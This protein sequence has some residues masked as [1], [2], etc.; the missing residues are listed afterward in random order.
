M[1]ARVE[2]GSASFSTRRRPRLPCLHAVSDP[3]GAGYAGTS[4]RTRCA[5]SSPRLPGP[6]CRSRVPA[7][8]RPARR[9]RWAHARRAGERTRRGG[10]ARVDAPIGLFVARRRSRAA[11]AAP[12]DRARPDDP[13]LARARHPRRR[14]TERP[15][16]RTAFPAAAGAEALPRARRG[17]AQERGPGGG[18]TPAEIHAAYAVPGD[19]GAGGRGNGRHPRIRRRLEHGLPSRGVRAW[20]RRR[21]GGLRLGAKNDYRGQT[22][23]A[24]VEVALDMDWVR[25]SAP[26]RRW[27]CGGPNVDTGGWTPRGAP[28]RAQP[29]D[30]ASCPFRGECRRTASRRRALRPDAPAL[31]V[32]RPPRDQF[33]RSAMPGGRR[34]AWT[35]RGTTARGTSTS[36]AS[37]L[38]SRRSAGRSSC[39]PGAGSPETRGMTGRARASGGG[40]RVSSRAR[41]AEARRRGPLRV[42]GVIPDVAAVAS[43]TWDCRS[44]PRQ[45]TAAGGERRGPDLGGFARAQRGARPRKS[46]PG[47]A[48]AALY[49]AAR[50][51]APFTDV[52]RR[53][54][55]R[56]V[57]APATKGWDPVTGLVSDVTRLIRSL[58]R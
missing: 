28:G 52:V 26:E 54:R 38:R 35:T 57:S 19:V 44:R 18:Y 15:A 51:P 36:R 8:L 2:R 45:V 33:L 1:P 47:A 21:H 40:F 41:L 12:T 53:Q 34:A 9:G 13:G 16:R 42:T 11:G 20:G 32:L 46:A 10:R 31:P 39:R 3:K 14:G 50:R 49:A 56:G 23:D 24:D 43:P 37:S 29:G 6:R 48:N 17:P 27:T 7:R 4:R 22:G 30:R 5:T 25:A 55:L 58:N